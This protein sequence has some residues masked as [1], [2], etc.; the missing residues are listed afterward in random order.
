M[1][2]DHHERAGIGTQRDGYPN[3]RTYGARDDYTNRNA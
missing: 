2:R 1:F 3:G